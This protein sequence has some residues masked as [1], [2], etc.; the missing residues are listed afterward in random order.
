MHPGVSG[1]LVEEVA[2]ARDII[3]RLNAELGKG[4]FN[5]APAK[6]KFLTGIGMSVEAPAG[7]SPEA[8]AS[9]GKAEF[10]KLGN[11]VKTIGIKPE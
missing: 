1:H 11:I 2:G 4:L 10:E 6:E 9:L 7:G 8:L 3:Q 5:N